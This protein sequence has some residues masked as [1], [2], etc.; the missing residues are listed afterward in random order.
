[1]TRNRFLLLT[2]FALIVNTVF[3]E[4][5]VLPFEEQGKFGFSD[6]VSGKRVVEPIYNKVG[7]YSEGMYAVKLGFVWGYVNDIGKLVIPAKYQEARDFVQGLACVRLCDDNKSAKGCKYGYIDKTGKTAILFEYDDARDF[8]EGLAGVQ[9]DKGGPWC[10]IN[11][12]SK[13][14]IKPQFEI[15]NSFQKGTA[16]VKLKGK[17]GTIDNTGKTLVPAVYDN[18]TE[19]YPGII[20]ATKDGKFGLIRTNGK[21]LVPFGKYDKIAQSYNYGVVVL[22]KVLK[23]PNVAYALLDTAGKEL[24]P[25]GTYNSIGRFASN[26]LA[27]VTKLVDNP[28][29]K[30]MSMLRYGYIDRKGKEHILC[31]FEKADE[32]TGDSALVRKFGKSF[33]I[34]TT[35]VCLRNCPKTIK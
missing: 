26:G 8:K 6:A 3:A 13:C 5:K 33:Y 2:A 25:Q 31:D 18:L 20:Q 34:N 12:K 10:Y 24:V 32:F 1:M 16:V 21:E 28:N 35:G 19:V 27:V 11:D 17:F 29:V 15:A 30:G 7:A 23:Q 22:Q 4:A 9:A 14:V